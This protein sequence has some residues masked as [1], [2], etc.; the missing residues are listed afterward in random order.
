MSLSHQGLGFVTTSKSKPI[1]IDRLNEWIR[2]GLFV[3]RER[4]FWSECLTFVRDSQGRM[5]AQGKLADA[6]TKTYDD[7]VMASALMINC[8]VWLPN[9]A[10]TKAPEQ[11]RIQ[12]YLDYEL[13]EATL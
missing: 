3:D 7:R 10:I 1:V 6:S 12:D 11:V 2:E 13:S 9:Y 8:S 4:Q 5:A